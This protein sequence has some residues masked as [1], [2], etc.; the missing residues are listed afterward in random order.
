MAIARC[1]LC[2]SPSK[3]PEPYTDRHTPAPTSGRGVRCGTGECINTAF[4][5]LTASEQR[6]FLTGQ[7]FFRYS[8]HAPA[9]ELL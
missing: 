3:S 2:G 4:V 9:V 5:W 1:E 8:S 7:R 6:S